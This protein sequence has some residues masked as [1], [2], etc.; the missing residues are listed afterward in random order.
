MQS[1]HEV[2][3]ILQDLGNSIED[4]GLNSWQLR[5]LS[6]VR[7][8]RTAALG[9]HVDACDDCPNINTC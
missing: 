9:G 1:K 5:T 8:C 7:R 6:A 2:A 3:D 4:L